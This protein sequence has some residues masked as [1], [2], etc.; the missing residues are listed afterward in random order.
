MAKVLLQESMP[1]VEAERTSQYT[2]KC[3]GDESHIII[4]D[5]D[6]KTEWREKFFTE[7]ASLDGMNFKI[8]GV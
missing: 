7:T 6:N 4:F 8:W 3:N 2:E 5:R 1:L